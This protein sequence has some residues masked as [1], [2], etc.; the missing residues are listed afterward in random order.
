[1]K[2]RFVE[3][4]TLEVSLLDRRSDIRTETVEAEGLCCLREE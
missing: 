2:L 4:E 1:V 3:D